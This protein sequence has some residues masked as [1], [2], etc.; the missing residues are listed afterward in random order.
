MGR[1]Q[2]EMVWLSFK[3]NHMN[4]RMKFAIGLLCMTVLFQGTLATRQ[5][6][7]LDDIQ[8]ILGIQTC[9]IIS[10]ICR[11]WGDI[12]GNVNDHLQFVTNFHKI[13]PLNTLGHDHSPKPLISM[14]V[15]SIA[16]D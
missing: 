16:W 4:Y 5:D 3:C 11:N 2:N 12:A 13:P 8:N 6:H 7:L 1:G 14:F 9:D 15:N 10:F